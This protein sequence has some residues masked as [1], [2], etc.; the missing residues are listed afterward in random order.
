[1][2]LTKVSYSMIQGAPVNVIDFGADSTGVTNS[3]TQIQAAL[4]YAATLGNATVVFP[5][6]TYK[7]NSG[8]SVDLNKVG[9]DGLGSK[10]DFSAM[11]TGTAITIT[12][13]ASLAERNAL[14]M[15]HPIQNMQFIG[16]GVGVTAVYGMVIDDAVDNM[17]P[18][19]KVYNCVFANF[20]HDV[21]LVNGA[22]CWLFES[23]NF[24]LYSG[25][26]TTY[27]IENGPATNSGE[28]NTFIDCMWNNRSFVYDCANSNS[29]T[30]FTNCSF[31]YNN[32]TMNI[33]GGAVYL[34]GCHIE[35]ITDVSTYFN[36]SS[37][38]TVLQ[39]SNSDII[40]QGAKS[41]YSPFYSDSTCAN[42]GVMLFDCKYTQIGTITVPL[43]GGTG[44]TV[45][46]NL[47]VYQSA[48]RPPISS[49]SNYL[50]YG[51]F[52]S[53]NYTSEWTLADGAV[54]SNVLARTGTYSL[55]FPATT[56]LSPTATVLIPCQPGAY[57]FGELYY[58]VPALSG[59]SG[60]FYVQAD[61]V[62][63]GGNSLGGSTIISVT[64][65]VSTWTRIPL[66]VGTI[67]APTGAVNA[68]LTIGLF[69][70]ASGTPIGYVD[71]VIVQVV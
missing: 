63:K 32:R 53:A 12:Q 55:S 13:S 50:A 46:T 8:L 22:F 66:Q 35:Q 51:G 27:S 70:V 42:G 14:N 20:A 18:S 68:K 52:E 6:G 2:S 39:V 4:T 21:A 40:I 44:R 1:M 33:S 67:T 59:T 30:F 9:I 41:A 64:S 43:I 45:T 37:T 65:S 15:V 11:T 10:L 56:V 69:G 49:F 28:R 34:V 3:A 38:N 5:S 36:V 24:T 54:R 23:C 29:S 60:T 7:C 17:I 19:G 71:D 26:P 48:S 62:D 61:W 31:D 25:T 47:S 58:Q 57:L 16:P